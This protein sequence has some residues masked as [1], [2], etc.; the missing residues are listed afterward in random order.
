MEININ[1]FNSLFAM[2]DAFTS[3]AQR[4]DFLAEQ[5]WG[6]DVVC[7]VCGQ[8]HCKKRVDGRYRCNHCKHNFS[9]LV[10][11]IF[12]N[13][14]VSLCKWFD[15]MYLVSSH[16]KGVSSHQIA[17]D[18]AITQKTAWYM[19]QK[20]R[21]LFA[22]GD[23]MLDGEVECDE[24]YIG[25]R[26]K[27]KHESKKTLNNQGRSLK[28][29]EAVFGM[30]QRGGM[31]VAKQVENTNS[32][33]ISDAIRGIVKP[34]SRIFTDEYI[35]YNTLRD[36]EYT[37]AVVHHKAKEFVV[38]EAHTNAI[39]GFWGQLKRMIFGIYHFVST[40]YL[41]RYID[42]AVFRYNTRRQKEGK[43]FQTMFSKAVGIVRYKDVVEMAA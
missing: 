38:G 11:T 14:K 37:H 8:H 39:E 32:K 18:L 21:T 1:Q 31:V 34:N 3:D 12:E 26:E 41:Q 43:R 15:A 28:T 29:K 23:V 17:R 2:H 19:L 30:I 36:S 10:G 25:G 16:K 33:T 40:K 42:E 20:I 7:S 13:S 6:D 5:R 4:K 9:V 24:A 35:G 22:Q 27:N